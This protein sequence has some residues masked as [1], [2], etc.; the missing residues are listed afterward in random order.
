MRQ[1]T[2]KAIKQRCKNARLPALL[3]QAEFIGKINTQDKH[4]VNI[5][6]PLNKKSYRGVETCST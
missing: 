2:A 3:S 6:S 1:H 5:F 4:R